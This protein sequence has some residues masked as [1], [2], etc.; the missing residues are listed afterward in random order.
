MSLC[1]G[2]FAP[3]SLLF[4]LFTLYAW[5]LKLITYIITVAIKIYFISSLL[6]FEVNGYDIQLFLSLIFPSLGLCTMHMCFSFSCALDFYPKKKLP[7]KQLSFSFLYLQISLDAKNKHIDGIK[8]K[9][10]T[11]S[12]YSD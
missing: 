5:I 4:R 2:V 8:S 6:I 1:V 7:F 10:I 11:N 12:K 9:A 3:C